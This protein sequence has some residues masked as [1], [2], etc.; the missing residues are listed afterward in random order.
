MAS[1]TIELTQSKSSG[2][3]IDGKIVWSSAKN[4]AG[5]YSLVDGDLYVKK[6]STTTTLASAT[7]GTWN[8]TFNIGG[9]S[10]SDGW[11]GSV[12]TSW[13]KVATLTDVKITHDDDGSK[14]ITISGSVSAPSGTS[15]EGHKTSGSKE[16]SLDSIARAS[17]PTVSASSIQMGKALTITTNRKSSGFTHTLKYTFG[18]TTKTIKTGV[19]ASY[20]WTVPDIASLCNNAKS[21]TCKIT[22]ITYNGKTEIGTK[23]VN[24]TLTVPSASS[25]TCPSSAT[26]KGTTSFTIKENSS[27][28]THTLKYTFGER[29]AT[30]ITGLTDGDYD[31]TIPNLSSYCQNAKRGTCKITCYTY[32]GTA[33]VGSTF[34]TLTL[35]VPGKSSIALS[36]SSVTMGNSLTITIT[37]NSSTFTH[38]VDYTFGNASGTIS[39]DATTKATWSEVPLDLAKQI[40]S[41]PSGKGKITCYTY[42]GSALIGSVEKEFTA[43]VPENETTKP[44]M[45]MKLS[46]VNPLS[47]KFNGIYVQGKS[48]VKAEYTA[49]S[50][51]SNIKSYK[52][53]VQ[54]KSYSGNPV[55]SNVLSQ[56]GEYT[57]TGAVTDER[58]FTT[59]DNT[60]SIEVIAYGSPLIIP[61][62]GTNSIICE[63]CTDNWELSDTGMNLRI[64]ARRSYSKVVSEGVQKNFCKLGYRIMSDSD[65]NYSNDV[66]LLD[67]DSTT[68]EVDILISG[69]VESLTTKYKVQL[70]VKDD[71]EE[72]VTKTFK[73]GAAGCVLHKGYGG[74]RL[75]L[76]RYAKVNNN[77]T[78]LEEDGIDVGADMFFDEGTQI[79]GGYVDSLKLGTKIEATAENHADL[80]NKDYLVPGKYYSP[81]TENSKYI[82][83]TPYTLGT[84]ELGGF[85]LEVREL[86]NEKY[87]RQTLY[88]GRTTWV[89][90]WNDSEWSAWGRHLMTT[91]PES[92][93]VDFVIE[94][95]T[96][97]GWTYKKWKSGTYEMFGYF[98][99][100]TTTAGVANGSLYNSEQFALPTP[101]P[102]DNAVV[103]GSAL[104]RFIVI[105]GGQASTDSNNNIGFRLFR[106]IAFDKG[107][108]ISVRL[109]VTGKYL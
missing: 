79:Y 16:V 58:G 31:W 60:Q 8:Y 64:R 53:T 108:S 32:N 49:S 52:T 35:N 41:D 34:D 77:G 40:K 92:S 83:N 105:S 75:G 104:S 71:I 70:F 90:H 20:S 76:K 4:D 7:Y 25:F 81:N 89:R 107:T 45:D 94:A 84:E 47:S 3:Y 37:R 109:H 33:L 87:I 5:N 57:V 6:G 19:G 48:Q 65:D 73:I 10:V 9:K 55:T 68:D 67:T 39:K 102:I 56:I 29:T 13:V 17:V 85:G 42:N 88:F 30:I 103:S 106:P 78:P 12:L 15:F 59:E 62:K 21:G 2:S 66:I 99:V 95:K 43:V 86:Q 38:K 72:E 24:V 51:Y 28:F 50:D 36:T 82:E 93:A 22:C 44:K 1:G 100:T 80:N 23:T 61:L 97:N 101:F 54:G 63:R 69:V 98:T 91:E 11:Y 26:M 18:G 27:N 74:Y 14:K 46:C 96:N